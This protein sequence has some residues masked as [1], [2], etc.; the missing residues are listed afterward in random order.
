MSD[1]D[2]LFDEDALEAARILFA[3]K[4][5]FMMGAVAMDGL[6]APD[7]PLGLLLNKN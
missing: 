3:R 4:A 1:T 7:L 6:P 5:E 2:A